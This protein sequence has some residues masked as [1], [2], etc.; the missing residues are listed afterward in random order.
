MRSKD[1]ALANG[2][3]AAVRGRRPASLVGD[4]AVEDL[5]EHQHDEVKLLGQKREGKMDQ[6][7]LATTPVTTAKLQRGELAVE[8]AKRAYR[9]S[10]AVANVTTVMRGSWR[11]AGWSRSAGDGMTRALELAEA[12]AETREREREPGGE[13]TLSTPLG[14]S[15]RPCGR[16]G[17]TNGANSD[18][19]T[20]WVQTRGGTG[21]LLPTDAALIQ[22][23]I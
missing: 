2:G 19:R 15:W 18:V 16:A 23:E 5:V 6:R 12:T 17:L 22:S 11:S 7:A 14:T 3:T 9:G 4:R 20:P 21:E 13:M 8:K 10:A 1:F